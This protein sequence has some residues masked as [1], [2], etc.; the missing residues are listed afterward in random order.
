MPAGLRPCRP[1]R[2]PTDGD[3]PPS[4]ILRSSLRL[5]RRSDGSAPLDSVP[6]EGVWHTNCSCSHLVVMIG[7]RLKMM[8]RRFRVAHVTTKG[9]STSMM[10][11]PPC[12][13]ATHVL[14]MWGK[15][16]RVS[17][18]RRKDAR[19]P[20]TFCSEGEDPT[21]HFEYIQS[22]ETIVYTAVD[23]VL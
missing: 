19:V 6:R 20:C 1:R 13:S 3:R 21:L 9:T 11:I 10:T 7:L 5:S 23:Y 15:R 14:F 18:S 16:R 22:I 8:H 12:R 4:S 17:I 2:G